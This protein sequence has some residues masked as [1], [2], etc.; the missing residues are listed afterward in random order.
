VKSHGGDLGVGH[1]VGSTL[2]SPASGDLVP[3]EL[4]GASSLGHEVLL[5]LSLRLWGWE[6]THVAVTG[7]IAR[8]GEFVS[9]H[10]V[11][12]RV[13]SEE[14][15]RELHAD[16]T[17]SGDADAQ[18]EVV[19]GLGEL[20]AH[21]GVATG[22]GSEEE[23]ISHHARAGGVAS[24]VV[25][26]EIVTEGSSVLAIGGSVVGPPMSGELPALTTFVLLDPGI[27]LS[28]GFGVAVDGSSSPGL[29]LESLFLVLHF[30][31]AENLDGNVH[32]VDVVGGELVLEHARASGVTDERVVGGLD[33]EAAHAGDA[34]VHGEVVLGGKVIAHHDVTSSVSSEEVIGGLDT[35]AAHAGD[36]NVHGEVVL[37]NEFVSQHAGAGRV[38]SEVVVSEHIGKFI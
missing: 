38:A 27:A 7:G 14:V 25:V 18:A 35:E 6:I 22:V 34:N 12:G 19:L 2:A 33:T 36:A 5:D 16:V 31:I 4:L 11:T 37:G 8:E 1:E 3:F 28:R 24:K 30:S 10:D 20:V 9:H 21:H 32:S 26:G 13:S 29:G 23:L 15:V 17:H